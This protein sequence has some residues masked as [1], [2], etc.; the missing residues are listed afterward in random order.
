MAA[1]GVLASGDLIAALPARARQA[2]LGCAFIPIEWL[3]AD[4]F[5]FLLSVATTAAPA[6]VA[7]SGT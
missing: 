3:R 1:F 7:Q 6:G 2:R 4:V 5:F